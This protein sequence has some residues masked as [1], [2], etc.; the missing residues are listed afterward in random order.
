MD[1][2]TELAAE[3]IAADLRIDAGHVHWLATKLEN[4][5]LLQA[6]HIAM[7]CARL[8]C[9]TL[10]AERPL[11]A[12]AAI[13]TYSDCVLGSVNSIE[14]RKD[15]ED[16]WLGCDWKHLTAEQIAADP[17]LA[18]SFEY[19]SGS[20]LNALAYL[21]MAAAIGPD[22]PPHGLPS[23]ITFGRNLGAP[24]AAYGREAAPDGT[25]PFDL[26]YLSPTAPGDQSNMRISARTDGAV[27]RSLG[28]LVAG[29]I[30]STVAPTSATA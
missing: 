27:I 7:R 26:L 10:A 16:N 28:N 1:K 17:L 2:D 6:H 23:A 4:A 15:A 5:S 14:I 13:A 8:L 30:G 9:A 29:R 11:D 18:R 25:P 24:F 19:L 20:A 3:L 21:I 22:L 12:P